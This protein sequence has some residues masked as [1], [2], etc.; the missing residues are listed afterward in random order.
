MNKLKVLLPVFSILVSNICLGVLPPEYF[1]A[2]ERN[3]KIKAIAIVKSVKS[4]F[5]NKKTG[6]ETQRV[7]FE[8]VNP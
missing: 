3:A 7:S 1:I 6:I 5:Y 4:G 8:T 2:R